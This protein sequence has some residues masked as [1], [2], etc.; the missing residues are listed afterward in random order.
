MLI[1]YQE[2][3]AVLELP[4][5]GTGLVV[6]DEAG[7]TP[8]ELRQRL[9]RV[10]AAHQGGVLIAVVTGGG[11]ELRPVLE[12]ADRE[13]HNRNRLGLYHLDRLAQL[14]RVA[15]RRLKLL[16]KA[17]LAGVAPFSAA[18]AAAL[19]ERGRKEREE[20][21][22][23]AQRLHARFPHVTTILLAA[24]VVMYGL[25]LHWRAGGE[26]MGANSASLVREGQVWRLLSHAFLHGNNAHLIMNMI[27]LHSFGGFLERMLGWRRY[28]VLYG[29][30]ALGGGIASALVAN[31]P[32]SVGASGAL[33][34]LMLAGFAVA[35]QRQSAIPA[36][37]AAGLRQRL[38]VVL[39]INTLLSFIPGIDFS[40]HFGGG[41]VG[42]LLV[43]TGLPP[44]GIALRLAAPVVA[45]ML[46][47]SVFLALATGQPWAQGSHP[48][49]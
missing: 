25:T 41:I 3:L 39:G 12:Q 45:L 13:A 2:P 42:Y 31:N 20:A 44:E 14:T 7:A 32:A 15:G 9:D 1:A 30:S 5:E 18:D 35:R 19:I 16:E 22:A 37:I 17:N 38:L 40:A 11:P 24:C 29:L 10:F 34:G 28:L 46:A 33:W 23:F 26:A 27:G 47:G 21:A 49:G 36:R 48:F 4:E 43:R 8:E 6:L